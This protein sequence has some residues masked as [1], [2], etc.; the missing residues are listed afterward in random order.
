M[1]EFR[2]KNEFKGLDTKI[3]DLKLKENI[4]I[5]AI[6]RDKNIIYP[7]GNEEIKLNDIIIIIDGENIVVDINDMVE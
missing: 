1:L 5:V 4:L 2:I 3:K 6:L 7:S